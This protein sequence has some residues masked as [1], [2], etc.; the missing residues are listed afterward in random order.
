MQT[1]NGSRT[2]NKFL[3]YIW[4]LRLITHLAN[5]FGWLADQRPNSTRLQL[6][7]SNACVKVVS[8]W[9]ID[10]PNHWSRK[11]QKWFSAVQK[12]NFAA[13]EPVFTSIRLSGLPSKKFLRVCCL[14]CLQRCAD[15][16]ISAIRPEQIDAMK[17]IYIGHTYVCMRISILVLTYTSF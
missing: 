17:Q 10:P 3:K 5:S 11:N 15:W 13:S 12:I 14:M 7:T 9:S 1:S 16:L 4:S 2:K 8:K 6:R